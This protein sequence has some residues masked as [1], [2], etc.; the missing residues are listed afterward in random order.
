MGGEL[1]PQDEFL[2][3]HLQS[4]DVLIV[5]VGGNDVAL[6]AT[7][8]TI[9]S[10]GAL[11]GLAS[12]SA[13]DAGNAWGFSHIQNLFGKCVE[14]YLQNLC[15]KT[16]PSLIILC[17]IYFPHE[18]TGDSW[19]DTA[20]SLLRYDSNPARLQRVIRKGY[21]LATKT[22]SLPGTR[23]VTCPLFEVL[24]SSAASADY[25]ARVE[26]SVIGGEKMAK[27]FVDII[28]TQYKEP[29]A[30]G[31]VAGGAAPKE[32]EETSP[33]DSAAAASGTSRE[34]RG[35]SSCVIA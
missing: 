35:S 22:V 2:R 29:A 27:A 32:A 8:S 17:M 12:D 6:K 20:L 23:I 30:A 16:R 1:L 33:D 5:S 19:A 18:K 24:D 13:I 21:D 3:D 25:V 7:A 28:A 31:T 10:M 11:V 9:A 26:P 4:N 15:S 14:D 34:R